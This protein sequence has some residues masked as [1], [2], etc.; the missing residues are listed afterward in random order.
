MEP[1][2]RR[3][4]ANL[5][6]NDRTVYM[7]SHN[8]SHFLQEYQ[9]AEE[10]IAG[11][12]SH[13]EVSIT[14]GTL[15]LVSDQKKIVIKVDDTFYHFFMDSLPIII[16]LKE[17]HPDA[18][19]VLYLQTARPSRTTTS[20]IELLLALMDGEGINYTTVV[21]NVR[22]GYA[23]ICK[24]NNFTVIG[25]YFDGN[26]KTTLIDV[27]NTAELV[28]KYAKKTL[29]VEESKEPFRKVYLT[30]GDKAGVNIGPSPEG[31]TFYKDDIRMNEQWKL[32]EFFS[33]MG[34]EV[35][36]PAEDFESLWHQIVYMSEVKTLASVTCSGLANMIFMNP[37]QNVIELQAEIVQS[38]RQDYDAV[39]EP[40]QGVHTMYQTL[41][42]M[43][44]H[45]LLSVPS[46]RDPD[47]VIEALSSG[48]ISYFI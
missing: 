4:D 34:Y 1:S 15:D 24:I 35:V 26:S 44:E 18:L 2:T 10:L 6:Y 5:P 12:N 22:D 33:S 16:R 40:K 37:R 47:R 27:N 43:K 11:I 29:G 25:P 36:N 14:P 23:P 21:T 38:D 20:I 48:T 45:L 13:G 9:S 30:R 39:V 31:Y 17:L 28:L 42:F 3:L 46:R 41:S 7:T 8:E 19:F 32:E